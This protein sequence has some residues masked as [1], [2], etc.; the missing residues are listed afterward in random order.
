MILRIV[1]TQATKYLWL[2]Y[3]GEKGVSGF[4]ATLA[5]ATRIDDQYVTKDHNYLPLSQLIS[6]WL[7]KKI[8][9]KTNMAHHVIFYNTPTN[10]GKMPRCIH[11]ALVPCHHLCLK[12]FSFLNRLSINLLVPSPRD[13]I[14]SLSTRSLKFFFLSRDLCKIKLQLPSNIC[15]LATQGLCRIIC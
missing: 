13:D 6:E 15:S 14:C 2:P 11:L 5:Y 7:K 8:M 12:N 4:S 9:K 10:V 1:L 3:I